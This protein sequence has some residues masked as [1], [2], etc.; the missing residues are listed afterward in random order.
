MRTCSDAALEN[1]MQPALSHE[2]VSMKIQP[3]FLL[4]CMVGGQERTKISQNRGSS[5][6]RVQASRCVN[7]LFPL[8]TAKQQMGLPRDA[9]GNRTWQ[10]LVKPP[11]IT[12]SV[13]KHH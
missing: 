2:E 1:L 12:V 11:A 4:K 13:L 5:S 10:N 3:C 9:P 6:L 8:T 7:N